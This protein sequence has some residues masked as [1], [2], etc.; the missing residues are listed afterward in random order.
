MN[1]SRIAAKRV[2]GR[3][4]VSVLLRPFVCPDRSIARP[5]KRS[6]FAAGWY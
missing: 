3:D 4:D 2:P 1:E 5:L 6:G